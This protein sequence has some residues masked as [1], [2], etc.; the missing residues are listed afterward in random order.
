[1]MH[2]NTWTYIEIHGDTDLHQIIYVLVVKVVLGAFGLVFWVSGLALGC[3]DFYL[4][5]WTC[6]WNVWPCICVSGLGL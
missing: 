6:V 1:M 2:E 4:G 5:V 3:L